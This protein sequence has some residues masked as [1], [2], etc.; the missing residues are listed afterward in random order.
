ML[1]AAAVQSSSSGM[2]LRRISCHVGALA[3]CKESIVMTFSI[4]HVSCLQIQHVWQ[5][6]ISL[7]EFLSA[8]EYS[9]SIASTGTREFSSPVQTST[10]V[11]S[12]PHSV[13]PLIDTATT[14]NDK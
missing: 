4:S 8:L 10:S 11:T 14:L 5:M 1:V 2:D 12:F 13:S 6:E 3:N 7:P 9:V